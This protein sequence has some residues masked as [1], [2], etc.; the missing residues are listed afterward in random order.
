MNTRYYLKVLG[1]GSILTLLICAGIFFY[2]RWDNQRFIAE[3][4]KAPEFDISP[5]PMQQRD[6]IP[7]E[8]WKQVFPSVTVDSQPVEGQHLSTDV[9][10]IQIEEAFFEDAYISKDDLAM[11]DLSLSTVEFPDTFPNTP[12]EGIEFPETKAAWQD[13]NHFLTTRPDYAYDRLYDGFR[14]MFGDRPEVDT[15][16]E[17]IR[18]ANAGA[19]T[20][21]DAIDM[22]TATINVM[23]PDAIEPIEQLRA[24]LEMF[25]ELKDLQID[26]EEVK[27]FFNIKVGE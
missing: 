22:V 13:Y 15:I 20:V 18:K 24:Q 19:L 6:L 4:P 1:L 21:D 10:D 12:I 16:V 8:R 17:V 2:V 9:P 14:E 3:L 23:P 26:G 11:E 27:V 7:K 5:E 25:R